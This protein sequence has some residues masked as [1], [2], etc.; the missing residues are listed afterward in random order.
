MSA[1]SGAKA[2]GFIATLMY[3]LKPV[4]LQL[5]PV[6]FKLT[7]YRSWASLYLTKGIEGTENGTRETSLNPVMARTLRS[8]QRNILAG[9]ITMGPLFVTWLVFSFVLEKLAKAGLPL[10][11]CACGAIF[12]RSG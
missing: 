3:G 9:M 5:K 11:Q 8:L 2:R 12:P 4:P 1:P 10:V 6:P 7:H